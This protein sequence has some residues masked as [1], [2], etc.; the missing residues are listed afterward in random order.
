MLA[1]VLVH[2]RV[3]REERHLDT[4]HWSTGWA[5]ETG[6]GFYIVKENEHK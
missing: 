3:E 4:R 6:R 2:I 1:Q 5:G